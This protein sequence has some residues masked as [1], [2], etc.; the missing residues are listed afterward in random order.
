MPFAFFLETS[1]SFLFVGLVLFFGLGWDSIYQFLIQDR[2]D[3]DWPP[4]FQL[5]A[6]L[7]E[8][9]WIF[10]LIYLWPQFASRP[11]IWIFWLHYS[12]VW[13]ATFTASQSLLRLLFP[14][15][16]FRGGQWLGGH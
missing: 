14:C 15:W 13:V 4:L 16:R 11:P 6:G 2:W 5:L 12:L 9:L 8:G 7:T 1:L 3:H 10:I